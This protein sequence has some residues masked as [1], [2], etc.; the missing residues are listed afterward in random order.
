M[1][2]LT[3]ERNHLNACNA[4]N[5]L[6]ILQLS[7]DTSEHTRERSLI[8]ARSAGSSFLIQEGCRN[9]NGHILGKS[10]IHASIVLNVLQSWGI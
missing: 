1:K 7:I 9:I 10:R 5:V 4:A 6:L 2:E 8:H 3:R